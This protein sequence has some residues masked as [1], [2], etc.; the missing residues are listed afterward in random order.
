MVGE[1]SGG[2]KDE[3]CATTEVAVE[4]MIAERVTKFAGEDNVLPKTTGS[5]G[6]GCS[7]SGE[8]G[9]AGDKGE[10]AEDTAEEDDEA[11]CVE[12]A[13]LNSERVAGKVCSSISISV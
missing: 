11:E 3:L 9:P 2:E 7:E 6:A 1:E 5:T 4:V 13:Q 10:M 8:G 12:F